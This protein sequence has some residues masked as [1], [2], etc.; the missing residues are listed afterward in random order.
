MQPKRKYGTRF[1]ILFVSFLALCS[2]SF[3]QNGGQITALGILD[4]SIH[5]ISPDSSVTVQD[6]AFFNPANLGKID[7]TYGVQNV[8]TLMINEAS[9]L[10]FRTAFSVTVTLH[11][12]YTDSKGDTASVNRN[13]TVG[14][15]SVGTYNSRSS[16]VFNGAHQVT[17]QVLSDSSNVSTWDPTTVLLIENQLTTTPGYLFS[18]S[19]TVTNIT[20]G[21]VAD[22]ADELPVSWNPVQG[23]NQYDLEWT[24]V[25]SSALADTT[26]N[27]WRYGRPP[28]NPTLIFRNSASRITTTG[29]SYN[30]PIIYDNTGIVFIRVRP[31][32]T[33][34]NNYTVTN[35]IWSSD[36]SPSV[37]GQFNF[38]GHERPL[39]WQSNIS[40][41][42][43]GKR[44][45]VVQYYD[46]SLRSRQTVTKD[47]TTNTTIVG[48][49]YYDYQGRPAIQVMPAPTLSTII[50]YKSG[51]SH[52]INSPQYSQSDYDTLPN[53]G[54]FC[55]IHADS[56]VS[57]S[58]AS[59]YYSPNYL[60]ASQG[61]NQFI[62]DAHD[63]PFSETEYMPDNT[64]R[65]KRQ[66]GV[67]P[68]HQLGTGHETKYFY[69][70]PDQNELD[71]LFGTEVGDKS[72]Y[73]K[74]MVRDANGQYS[75]AY[76]DMHGRTIATALAG[77]TPSG[78]APL[79]SFATRTIT[80]TLADSN[81]VSI[82]GQSMVSQKTL[83]VPMADT[84]A[85]KYNFLADIYNDTSCQN[86][87]ICYTCRYD[88]NITIT[89]NCNNQLLGGQP[90]TISR[91]NFSL[92]SL[93]NCV[94]DSM[95]VNFSLILP[96]GS[97]TITKTLTVDPGVYNFYLDSIY[98]PN[99][100]CTT[101]G[102]FISQQKAV[103][104]SANST[105]A[106]TCAQCESSVGTW[107]QFL[108]NYNKAIGLGPT[109]TTYQTEA[110]AAYQTAL[111]ACST[112][113]QTNTD[114]NDILSAMLADLTPPYG[115]YADT[116]INT[117]TDIYSIFYVK[118]NPNPNDT[119]DYPPVY[120]LPQIVYLDDNGKPDSVYDAR[121]GLT[122][123]PNELTTA[124]F[125]QN[126][127]PS[128]AN[129][130]LP[131]HPEYCKLQVLQANNN[132]LLYDR[133]MES[134][135]TYQAALDS[136]FLNPTG[137]PSMA[138]QYPIDS[139]NIDPLTSRF[140]SQL[141][142]ILKSY[143]NSSNPNVI[144]TLWE[145]ACM[146]VTCDS[147]S[148]SCIS[149]YAQNPSS[150]FNQSLMCPGDLDM[151]WRN[152]REL[153]LGQKQEIFY[154]NLLSDNAIN[155]SGVCTPVN[156]RAY[157]K[158]PQLNQLYSAQH[159]PEF[160]DIS[161]SITHSSLQNYSSF[162]GSSGAAKLQANAQV[163]L[164]SFYTA[165]VNSY[166]QQWMQ[167]LSAC[168]VYNPYDV[169]NI[170]IPG[171]DSLCRHACDSAHPYGASTLPPGQTILVEGLSCTSFE[172]IINHYNQINNITDTLNCNAEVITAPL[173][174]GSQ[175]IYSNKPVYTR[176]S[177]CECGLINDLYAQYTVAAFGDT[178]FS[179]WLLRTHQIV[180]SS[181]DLTTLRSMCS[182]TT[183]SATCNYV[184]TPI[185]LPPAMQCYS[186]STCSSCQAI[187][188][189]YAA[190]TALYPSQLP[191]DSANS[192]TAQAQ[193]NTLF[194][195]F[196]NNRL[197]YNLKAWEYLQFMD[198]CTAHKA[199]TA[200]TQ[201]CTP[202]SIAQLFNTGG[203]D[204][205]YDMKK[206]ADGGYILV[207]STTAQTAGGLDA[208]VIR[209]D[210]AGN[211]QWA[212][213]HGGTG[214]DYFS[215]VRVTS[216]NG[217]IAIGTTFSTANSN[218]EMLIVKMDANGDT[219]WEKT[220]GFAGSA[221]E[222]GYDIIQTSDHGYA[223]VGDHNYNNKTNQGSGDM[224]VV[225]LDSTGNVLWSKAL[226]T[227]TS[228]DGYGVTQIGDTLFVT[229]RN[230]QGQYYYG[231]LYKLTAN[232]GIVFD[233]VYLN[234]SSGDT[235]I[236]FSELFP[237]STG[238]RISSSSNYR[239]LASG[240]RSSVTD[241]SF[242]DHLQDYTSFN[243][244]PL[245]AGAG[246]YTNSS[247]FLPTSDG[248][249]LMGETG[250]NSQNIY[251][252]KMSAAGTVSWYK[253][254]T[255]SGTQSL[256]A[257]N[258][259]ADGSYTAL[260]ADNGNAMLLFLSDTGTTRCYDSTVYL[261]ISNPSAVIS[262]PPPV[263]SVD[264]FIMNRYPD[265][266]LTFVPLNVTNTAI[267]CAGSNNCYTVYNGPTLCGKSSPILIPTPDST[268][269]CTDSTF[270][271][272]T[273][274]TALYNTYSDSLTGSFE[275]NYLKVCML[276]YKHENFTVTHTQAEYHFML[277]YY[278][279][280]GNLLKTVPPAGVVE[281]T[282]STWLSQVR[283]ARAA[284]QVLVPNHTL[285]SNYRYNT[286][287][288][289]VAQQTPDG[290]TS[291]FWYDRLGRQTI[292]ENSRQRPNNQ[293]SY[294]Q[295]D[296]IGRITQVGQIVSSTPV[297]DA[298]SRND[299]TLSAWE[300]SAL[301]SAD[302]ITV[303]TYDT[304]S[305]A[306]IPELSPVNLRNRVAWT[307][308]YNHYADLY[309]S[310]DNHAAATYYSY[311]ILGNVDT[312]VQD[313]KIGSMASNGNRFKK[314]VFNFDLVSSRVNQ[315]NYQH[316]F[317]DAFYHNYAYDAENRITNVQSSTDSINWDNDA[318]Y[319]YYAHGPLARTILGPQQVQG[320]N[321]AYTLQ[322][323]LKA[324]NPTPN[325]ASPFTLRPDSS[326]N[327][328]ANTA[329]NLLLD[330]YN[331]DYNPISTAASPD[332]GVSA[333][334]GSYYRPLYNG[335]ISSMGIRIRGLSNP[336]LYNYQYDQLNRLVQMDAWNKT[337]TSWNAITL[338]PD[339]QERVAYD[340]NGNIQK[341]RRN[342]NNTFA[343]QPIGMDSLNYFYNSGTN[344]LD[345]VTDSVPSGNYTTDI[346]NQS[347]GNYQYDSI[348]DLIAD[349]ASGITNI[350]WTLYGKIGS[351]TKSGD[352]T[353][354]FTYDAEGNRISKSI[355][356]SGDTIT[357]WYVRDPEGNVLSVYT[358]GDPTISGKDLTQSELHIYGSSRL[359]IWN[360]SLNVQINPP[361]LT[362][363]LPL[364][365]VAD[366][367]TFARG[368]KLFELT[369]HL[370]NV[371]STISDKR[372][373]VSFDDSTVAYFNPEVVS[374]NDYYPFG[375]LQP[376]RSFTE[377]N[378]PAYRY[379]FNG[380]ENDN[381][382]KGLGD[383]QDYGLRIYD[384][385][386]GR[387]LS[388][389]P[390]T[391][392]FPS[393]TPYQFAENRPIIATDLD[394][395][396]SDD[397]TEEIK[398]ADIP[399]DKIEKPGVVKST[400]LLFFNNGHRIAAQGFA[401]GRQ[402]QPGV[403][404]VAIVD[405]DENNSVVITYTKAHVI[406]AN[407]DGSNTDKTEIIPTYSVFRED[408]VRDYAFGKNSEGDLTEDKFF[409]TPKKQLFSG[410]ILYAP[411]PGE[412]A[413]EA[414]SKAGAVALAA[415]KGGKLATFQYAAKYG[416]DTYESLRGAVQEAGLEVHHLIEK[417]FAK[418]LAVD[419]N[420][421]SSIVLTKAEHIK[422]TTLW[423]LEI[424]YSNSSNVL[425]TTTA[426]AADVKAAARAIYKNYPEIL[427]A[428]GL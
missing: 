297:T 185:Y 123:P 271:G 276:A 241:I 149:A 36:A 273:T 400:F 314:I 322:G 327:V 282:D 220:I 70:A 217:Y 305:Y 338:V 263:A 154:Q 128:W 196:M 378:V 247:A 325:T 233:S 296:L 98:L 387:F 257:I 37:M 15:D 38:R 68:Y 274:G 126:F 111:S 26:N 248:G 148:S 367:L 312:L 61:L 377:S 384:P 122:V 349:A 75:V 106:P 238:Y 318:F 153:Y 419:A 412:I 200:T 159:Q 124:E 197:G 261:S 363:S 17:V 336:L 372:Y 206:T 174:Y 283:A 425:R 347:V 5:Q 138:G 337:S 150:A 139:Y 428:L 141:R 23:A 16:F 259:N 170:I 315:V 50:M 411:M 205:M 306:I 72:H 391:G 219:L 29:T 19:N 53:P 40:Y 214:D 393:L 160:S 335:N 32:Q 427:K 223:A 157:Q 101:I 341:Y 65:T 422:F 262:P 173:P 317:A 222:F 193:K 145:M 423:R 84:F 59:R 258:Q 9:T 356:Y 301:D 227:Q 181:S 331:G 135:D 221:G 213:K 333:T 34:P 144:L 48:E 230:Y 343:G 164:D 162:S 57:D 96:E 74:N 371:L 146:M 420:K 99:N 225:R 256:G 31:V 228:D 292:S 152:F 380:K 402:S 132:S 300:S 107:P 285:V 125:A 35:A 354:L 112:L 80:E 332:S 373:G 180:M 207:G 20:V 388:V 1:I 260:G 13:F 118:P 403:I 82:Q 353:I 90:Y 352:T 3:A 287:N 156:N 79:P 231:G 375:S 275:Q 251:W 176:P 67:G 320:I 344:K 299:S 239:Y 121:S 237:T 155:A 129:A 308:L 10:Y 41:A 298:I 401:Y 51:L 168:T 93:R 254:T 383:Q 289:A 52:S 406:I 409:S 277:Y 39:N 192:D 102:Q 324:I 24:W 246:Q 362:D 280:A 73:F 390:L 368:N 177:D 103:A 236:T 293:Y 226:G 69:G 151:A 302:Q 86:Q 136:G 303:T 78:M 328:V 376:G 55:T 12:S 253:Q 345:H 334:L 95:N 243:A 110:N 47:N 209:Y 54:S 392:S 326:N 339:F 115:Q 189:L 56:M 414:G 396:E 382:V 358:Y 120:T 133:K 359:G 307:A 191:S 22:T 131:Y 163:S 355:A 340:P 348:G 172:D 404:G 395:A 417:R 105:C 140:S 313:F 66:S 255:L 290:G 179:A 165:N 64:G 114:A 279:Q 330:Y 229:G 134:I 49:T 142:S 92:S 323:W 63:Y 178:S 21:T 310:A 250:T 158:E 278:D 244:P 87:N 291:D 329:Y 264:S 234:Y 18:C 309:E 8:V 386:I 161:G 182:N 215:K 169:T 143:P 216:D 127:R 418:L 405:I 28:Y 397:K 266:T 235:T 398:E 109:D 379:G 360:R 43:E 119:T 281:N 294:T 6:T 304:A 171:L 342:G 11:I 27:Y 46:G 288:H 270:F 77:L 166:V 44:K 117:G 45:V 295:Y 381:E 175:P 316:G 268:T 407:D 426:T 202:T 113:C 94:D 374:A 91:Q 224:L 83:L 267:T 208:Y 81:S 265:T 4:G 203:T 421:M 272:E 369:N 399:Q 212:K 366:S 361:N 137:D 365:G 357:T 249:Y 319:S 413:E 321:Y 100:V 108:A 30:I 62:P 85:F 104:V 201:S 210:Q 269:A 252:E 245:N 389:D 97:Y 311:D 198:T 190:Y 218:N 194:A 408:K 89:D 42:E 385:R 147:G 60:L 188:A 76:V 187:D 351:I 2:S 25:D 58:G 7:S 116:S 232:T 33:K 186:G 183:N 204:V 14:Y 286:L 284:G 199:D 415:L 424:G 346:D 364:L 88:L 394:G 195:N 130:L 240:G 211:V 167:Q 370:G 350:T 416:I 242:N 184:S 71:A 410:E